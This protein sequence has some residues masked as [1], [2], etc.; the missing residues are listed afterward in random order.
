M[1]L[2]EA[3]VVHIDTMIHNNDDGAAGDG[4]GVDDGCG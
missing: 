1:F 2:S 3:K 4:N